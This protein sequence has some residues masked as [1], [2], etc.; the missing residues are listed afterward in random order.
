MS[1][2]R[3]VTLELGEECEVAAEGGR[4][5]K[6]SCNPGAARGPLGVHEAAEGRRSRELKHVD[7]LQA[8]SEALA[9]YHVKSAVRDVWGVTYEKKIPVS[10]L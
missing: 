1:H 4:E 2:G 3:L 7:S 9:G 10:V 8:C 5:E 6:C